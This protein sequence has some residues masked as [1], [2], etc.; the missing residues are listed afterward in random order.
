[1][2]ANTRVVLF[3]ILNYAVLII[4]KTRGCCFKYALQWPNVSIYIIAQ[5]TSRKLIK[6]YPKRSDVI[7]SLPTKS[8]LVPN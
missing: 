8:Y 4:T 1:M 3:I 2:S 6:I 7:R 5:E